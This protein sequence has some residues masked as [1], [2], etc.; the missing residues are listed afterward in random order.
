MSE[1]MMVY[2][3]MPD[4]TE[5]DLDHIKREIKKTVEK[6]GTFKGS[7]EEKV[8]FGLKAIVAKLVVPDEGGIVDKIEE[9]LKGI[10]EVQSVSAE[11][12]TLI[13]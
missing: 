4:G 6:H 10:E 13:D 5:S 2:K 8:A 7:S 1:V 3:V 11:D 12:V 9:E